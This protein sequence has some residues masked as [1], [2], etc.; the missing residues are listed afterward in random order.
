[1]MQLIV[2]RY[3]ALPDLRPMPCVFCILCLVL[4]FDVVLQGHRKVSL[5]KHGIITGSS[6]LSL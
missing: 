4:G 3:D 6:G 5:G 1:M 2:H